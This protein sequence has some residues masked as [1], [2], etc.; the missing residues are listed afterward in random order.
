ME[1]YESA[2]LHEAH[3]HTQ[4][5]THTHKIIVLQ[6]YVIYIVGSIWIYMDYLNSGFLLTL[7]DTT[8]MFKEIKMEHGGINMCHTVVWLWVNFTKINQPQISNICGGRL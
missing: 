1:L 7:S 2:S 4:T 3:G 5:H 8:Q 6:Q